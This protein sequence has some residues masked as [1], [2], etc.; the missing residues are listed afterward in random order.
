M[1]IRTAAAIVAAALVATAAPAADFSFTG[2]FVADNGTAGYYFVV[3]PSSTA[4]IS[5]LGYAGGTNLAGQSI[6][7]GGFDS[8]L[9]LYDGSGQQIDFNDDGDGATVDLVSGT[10]SDAGLSLVLA[11]GKYIVYLS[12][13]DNFG[14]ASLGLPFNFDGQPNFRGGFIDFGGFQRN[15][16]WALD[17]SGVGAAG[18][19][20][21]PATWAL[22]IGGFGMVGFTARRRRIAVVAA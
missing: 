6:A 7:A 16:N 14:P 19:V 13:Y 2:S 3:T 1:I 17:I 10:A 20:P 22:M 11:A 21:E 9:S 5:S 12:Q 15:G 8:V 18:A 4:T